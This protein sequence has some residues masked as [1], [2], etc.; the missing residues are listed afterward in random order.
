M[1]SYGIPADQDWLD[2]QKEIIA[3]A[4]RAKEEENK[5]KKEKE[6]KKWLK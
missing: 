4:E 1:S 3:Q 5:K 2:E 6:I